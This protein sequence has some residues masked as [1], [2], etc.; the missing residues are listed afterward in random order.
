[1]RCVLESPGKFVQTTN[2]NIFQP[3][4][5]YPFPA[6]W[7]LVS[8]LVNGL[9]RGLSGFADEYYMIA[10]VLELEPVITTPDRMVLLSDFHGTWLERGKTREMIPGVPLPANLWNVVDFIT[11]MLQLVKYCCCSVEIRSNLP[12]YSSIVEMNIA[13]AACIVFWLLAPLCN[14]RN[15]CRTVSFQISRSASCLFSRTTHGCQQ[16][17]HCATCRSWEVSCI[18]GP[19]S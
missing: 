5:L 3:S 6:C 13:T 18:H 16:V 9:S 11:R 14:K 8:M 17:I 19:D 7:G 4:K 15:M 1:M 12:Y 2:A 10:W